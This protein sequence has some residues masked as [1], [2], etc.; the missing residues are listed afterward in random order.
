MLSGKMKHKFLLSD[1]EAVN[2]FSDTVY[3]VAFN[4]LKNDADTQ[5]VFQ[6]VFLRFIK[7]SGKYESLEHAKAWIIR[8]T[9]N[10]SHDFLRKQRHHLE[11]NAALEISSKDATDR[12]MTHYIQGLDEKYRIVIHLFYYEQYKI[13]EIADILKKN[14][15][16]IKTWLARAKKILK[17]KWEDDLN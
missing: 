10:C 9:I 16:T 15:N 13:S 14:E 11:L 5:D 1:E 17:E 6:E 3:R 2:H 8:V 12:G 7:H 4:M